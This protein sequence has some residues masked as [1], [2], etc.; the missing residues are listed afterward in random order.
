MPSCHDVL[1]YDAGRAVVAERPETLINTIID[2][3]DLR[4]TCIVS[5]RDGRINP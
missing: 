2:F 4:E 5:R 3:L 1:V